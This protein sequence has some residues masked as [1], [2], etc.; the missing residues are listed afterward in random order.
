[1]SLLVLEARDRIGGRCWTRFEPGLPVPI[2]LGAEFIHGEPQVTL[3][4]LREAGTVAIDSGRGQRFLEA[5]RLRAV[6]GFAEAKK[7]VS[8]L[9]CLNTRDLSFERFL[10]LQEGLSQRTRKMARMMVEGFDAADPTLASARAIAQE[11][12]GGMS[13][14]GSQPRPLGGYGALLE[15][16]ARNQKLHL[17]ALVHEVRWK[18]GSVRVS[19]SFLGEPFSARARRALITLPL[20]VLQSGAVRFI[21]ALS[22]KRSALARLV[23]GPVVKVAL[24]FGDPF[25]ERHAREVAFFHAP[26]APFPT[27]WNQLPMR[28]PLLVGWAGGPKASALRQLK[29]PAIATRVL[30]SLEA[31]FGETPSP[32]SVLVQDWQSDPYARGAYSY[33]RVGGEGARDDLA[34][35]LGNTLFFAGEATDVQDAGTVGGALHSGRRAAREVL[36]AG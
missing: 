14:G 35:S 2:E 29:A 18:A 19:G 7:A 24:R 6:D 12:G 30:Q 13:L 33:V 9:S 21:P 23:S 17:G 31:M 22:A 15:V 26:D 8:D 28:A 3:A 34:A 5:G 11:W 10:R 20:G 16:L 32:E 27:F 36:A 25:W 1:V 4:L